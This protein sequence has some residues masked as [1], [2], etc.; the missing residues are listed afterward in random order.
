MSENSKVHLI[1]NAHLDP[2]WLWRWQE[3]CGEVLQT[4]RSAL[5]RLSE[6]DDFIFTCSSAAYYNWVKEINPGMFDE[7]TVRV[8]EGRWVPVNGWWVQPDCNIPSAESFARQALYSQLFYYENFGTVCRTGYNVDSFG[9]NGNLPQ[10]L[11]LGGMDCYVMMRPGMHENPDIPQHAFLWEGADGSRVL[12]FRIPE[13]YA[14]SGKSGLDRSLDMFEKAATEKNYGMMMFYGVGNHG[15]GPTRGDI[16]YLISNM[17]RE[18]FHEL[19]FSS[20]DG[21][22]Q[23]LCADMPDLP[24]WKNDL[25][26]HASGCYSSTSLVK[27]LNRHAENLIEGAEMLTTAASLTAGM[28]NKTERFAEAWK[29]IC[30]NQFHDILCG[31]SIMEAYEDVKNA[32]GHAENIASKLCNEACLRISDR[33][34]TWINGV[35]DPVL[36]NVV[37]N[38]DGGRFPRPIVVFNPLSFEINVPIRTYHPS[39]EVTDSKG[40]PVVFQNVRSSRSNDSHLDTVFMAKVPAFGYSVYHLKP[41]EGDEAECES[42]VKAEENT[43]TI[44]NEFIRAGFSKETGFIVSLVDK[45]SGYDYAENSALAVPTVIDDHVADTWAHNIFKFPD[46]KGIME[47]KSIELVEEG[48]ARALVRTR[49]GFGSSLLTQDFILGSHQKTLRVKCK[50]FWG[51]Q[52]TMLKT[53]FPVSG[54][55]LINTAEIPGAFIKRPCNGDEEPQQRWTDITYT[56]PD[57]IRR[58]LSLIND[59]KYSY[60][61]PENKLQLTL[62]RNVIFADHY[63]PRP[64]ADFNFTDEGMQRFE[65][66]IYVHTGEAEKSDVVKEA[67]QFNIRP[68]AV[69]TSFHRGSEPQIKSFM[70]IGADNIIATALKFAEDGSGEAILRCY[71]TKGIE[72]DTFITCDMLNMSVRVSFAPNE[73]KTFRIEDGG[74]VSEVN[75]LEGNII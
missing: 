45:S 72:T 25:Q 52:F 30:F 28:G 56:A 44:E 69:P 29:E 37:R 31:C 48:P 59:S 41:Y 20:P 34:D 71:E 65:Y 3:G 49:H 18:G 12:T 23:S 7:I 54:S 10:L 73:I 8:K 61:C 17:R 42:D 24:V 62:L 43:L 55:D 9:H 35:S 57:G 38:H 51:E 66:G 74:I 21:Y 40:D 46:V 47:L 32:F 53:S 26:H 16:E 13:T 4:F 63:S 68:I 36:C 33:I 15:G 39:D 60:D 67:A 19:E 2:V 5:D 50:A 6:Y 14:E 22:F 11:R 70:T 58:G 75:F 1:G 27:Q 64:A